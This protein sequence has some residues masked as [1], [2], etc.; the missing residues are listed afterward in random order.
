MKIIDKY[1]VGATSYVI[2]ELSD[3]TRI[4]EPCVISDYIDNIF[5]RIARGDYDEK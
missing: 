4:I 2:I 3:G 1:N 5:E